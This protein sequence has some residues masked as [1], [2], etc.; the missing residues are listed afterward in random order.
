MTSS[1][2]LHS[3]HLT[4]VVMLLFP[5]HHSQFNWWYTSAPEFSCFQLSQAHMDKRTH[6]LPGKDYVASGN[7]NMSA[8]FFQSLLKLLEGLLVGWNK[9]LSIPSGM[10]WKLCSDSGQHQLPW[11]ENQKF[12]SWICR[13][14][15]IYWKRKSNSDTVFRL[16]FLML[17]D[18]D[19]GM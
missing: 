4:L 13:I 16:P 19:H 10:C 2:M 11:S 17:K 12:S 18:L 5:A 8:T 6:H 7:Q 3:I 15:G 1:F 9:G 14:R